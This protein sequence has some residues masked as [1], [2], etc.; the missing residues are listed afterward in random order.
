MGFLSRGSAC[1]CE[2][3][4]RRDVHMYTSH[5]H[6]HSKIPF[7]GNAMGGGGFKSIASF[8]VSADHWNV[9]TVFYI[10]ETVFNRQTNKVF[11][12]L[13]A[14][15]ARFLPMHYLFFICPRI[16]QVKMWNLN[17]FASNQG[18]SLGIKV[19]KE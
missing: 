12:V 15:L 8:S 5:K 1:V 16:Y 7:I 19:S 4:P 11:K 9:N 2:Q 3:S 14:K 6:T 13:Y 10:A 17:V 18:K